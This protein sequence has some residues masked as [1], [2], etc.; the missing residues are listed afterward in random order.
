M[1]DQD[2]HQEELNTVKLRLCGVFGGLTEYPN[3]KGFWLDTYHKL[4]LDNVTVW[5]ILTTKKLSEIKD[6]VRSAA[7]KTK[8]FTGQHSQLYSINGKPYFV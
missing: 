5:E 1:V 8:V 6:S 2:K 7:I 3:C 4:C